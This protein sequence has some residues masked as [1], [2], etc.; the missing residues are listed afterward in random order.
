MQLQG[1]TNGQVID[2]RQEYGVNL[3]T[4][5]SRTPWW[6]LFLEKF[7][8][9]VVRILMFAAVLALFV[10]SFKGEYTEALGI[11]FAI[12][13]A[14]VLAFVNEFKASQE[15][16]ILNQVNDEVLIK[17]IRNGKLTT[18][19]K[20]DLVFRDIVLVE[21]GEEI[22]A[23]G[24]VLEA[25]SLQ[26]DESSL[27]GES[28]P[29][30]KIA[31]KDLRV[32]N[33]QGEAI[34]QLDKVLR[35][36][37]VTDG[38][39]TIE[40]TAVGDKTEIG[41]TARAAAVETQE[42]TPLNIQLKKLS[43]L[44]GV[45]A[46]LVA[47]ITL[48]AIIARGVIEGELNLTIQQ[49]YLVI[50]IAISGVIAGTRVWLPVI[51]S[52]L[53]LIGKDVEQPKWLEENNLIA[54][55][56]TISIGL[57]IFG[58]ALGLGYISG[59]LHG[60]LKSLLPFHIV[61][62]LLNYFMIAVTIIVVAVP[63]GLTMSVT[64]SLAYSMKK[65]TA[66]NNLVRRLD[67]C[68]TIGA[69]TV[70]C[71]DKTGTLTQNE[72]RVQEV[73]FPS[74]NTKLIIKNQLSYAEEMMV[75]A[76][77]A[78]TTAHLTK[79]P[80]QP[81]SILG[82]PTEGALLLWLDKKNINYALQRQNFILTNQWTFSSERKYMATLGISSTTGSS[83]LHLKG[84]PEIVLNR[85]SHI[86]T[87]AGI[88]VINN[89]K[90]NIEQTIKSYQARGIR[91]LG[92]AYHQAPS[93]NSE[94]D[95][96][97]LAHGLIWLGFIA[98]VDPVR[99]EV[100]SIIQ[101]CRRAGIMVKVV[102]GDNS[103]TAK[104]IARQIGLWHR[105]DGDD[106]HI[107]GK[108]FE[109]LNDE[110]A[111][112]V[113]KRVKVVSR[114]RPLDKLRLVKLLQ[115]QNE[116]VAVTGD[117]SNDAPALNNANVGLAMGKK[118]SSQAKEASD[119]I[120]LDDSFTSI[121][122]AVMWGRSLYQNIQRFILFQLTINVVAVGIALLGPFIGIKLPL[123][124][125]QMLWV[126]LIMD[127][128]AA[129][130]LATEPPSLSVMKRRPRNTN[131][132]II[133]KEMILTI[134]GTSIIFL[135]FLIKLLLFIQ[136]QVNTEHYLSI[137]FSIFVF[138]Q[139]W[140]LFNAKCFGTKQSAFSNLFHNKIFLVIAST[141][142]LGQFFIVQYGGSIFRTVPLSLKDCILIIG[143]TSLVL[144]IGELGRLTMRLT[145]MINHQKQIV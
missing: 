72:M 50:V 82:N 49:W 78:N 119:I 74:V 77:C 89:Y 90:V 145:S 6:M 128:F 24:R 20:K 75:E 76:I 118:G 131:D 126:N 55:I 83:I 112:I 21:A 97:Q 140:N 41:E 4:P 63:E 113:A 122:N 102:T 38:Y 51:F 34:Y 27:T 80:C 109:K 103:E 14:T 56:K 107:T 96:E 130:A 28:V 86:L 44:I 60:S 7:N 25:V 116:I 133:T 43:E 65:M 141:I 19:P 94:V 73:N 58:L 106:K 120:L 85:C 108:E 110:D 12:I 124:V 2:N 17:V 114:A 134:L 40:I 54:W 32:G 101:A 48:I 9:P 79:K 31:S 15:F 137:F 64:L 111:A 84:A 129:L 117:G 62:E 13:L 93:N 104:E 18:V 37:I 33:N 81:L 61:K 87:Q 46:F 71:S 136:K 59:F 138:L 42:E 135:V 22:P 26:V 123:T 105:D 144:W 11:I 35:G 121:F 142:A 66:S 99:L 70:I 10:G 100:P 47:G 95:V 45:L 139:F 98:L 36:T 3:L 5:P 143:G 39:G 23:D 92:F 127:T 115:A 29:V 69:I 88:E 125:A 30:N 91:V 53:E 68:E 52:G 8:D 132:F 1:L 67:A 16:N 57:I